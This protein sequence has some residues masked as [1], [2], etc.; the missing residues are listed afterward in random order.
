MVTQKPSHLASQGRQQYNFFPQFFLH[1]KTISTLFAIWRVWMGIE[2]PHLV[3]YPW[4]VSE[5]FTLFLWKM[6]KII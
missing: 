3:I 1:I 2:I 6:M 4:L 5:N